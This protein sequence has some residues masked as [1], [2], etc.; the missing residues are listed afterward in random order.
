MGRLKYYNPG[1]DTWEYIMQGPAGVGVPV[2]G[3]TG[4]AL[5]KSSNDDYDTDWTTL[6]QDLIGDGSTYKQY[7]Q[8]EKTKLGY[9]AITQAVNLDTMES[10]L[11]SHIANT[12]NPHSVTKSQVGLG[13]ADNT[14]DVN[15]PI[16]TATQ[17]AL[18]AKV[19]KNANITGAT[20]TKLTYDAKGL[21]TAGADATQDDIGDGTT[22]KQYSA[23]DKT[24]L[25]GIEALADVTDTA[26]VTAAGALMDSEVTNLAAVKAFNPAAYAT[27]AQGTTADSAV[28]PGDDV[29][30]LV[31]DAG[32]ITTHSTA[33]NDGSFRY[34]VKASAGSDSN[35]GLTSGTAFQTL[36]KALSFYNEGTTDLRIY[37]AE[38]GTYTLEGTNFSSGVALH[39]SS[40]VSGVTLNLDVNASSFAFYNNHLNISGV[41]T[42][43]R[44]VITGDTFHLDNADVV[45]QFTNIAQD[46]N[47]YGSTCRMES[48]GFKEIYAVNSS[49]YA[50]ATDVTNT[51]PART[52]VTLINSNYNSIGTW[53]V[54]NLSGAG[55]VPFF[56]ASG[57]RISMESGFL[58]TIANKYTYAWELH[59]TILMITS[60]RYLTG[61]DVAA[62][63]VSNDNS[64]VIS[65][66]LDGTASLSYASGWSGTNAALR[67]GSEVAIL[68]GVFTKTSNIASGDVICTIPAGYRPD[69][70]YYTAAVGSTVD[71][72]A[73]ISINNST[74]DVTA[75][76]PSA[77]T[78][79]LAFSIS[80]FWAS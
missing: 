71:K 79:V 53:T 17:T 24:K 54:S 30:D 55:S 74:G 4:Q 6:T 61:T 69:V 47:L 9:I 8:T 45:F 12:S 50:L 39:L 59:E 66:P 41:D 1:T 22:Y 44:L 27:A 42:S 72:Q 7:S 70:I 11:S 5:T 46:F 37:L 20:K 62:S 65:D 10:D 51:D 73:R 26:N 28:Q 18:D 13:N 19:A 64:K 35:D 34:Y 60:T 40:T 76:N 29:S 38:A 75:L 15:K 16:S 56:I 77:T 43:N 68:S 21:V 67:R 49:I 33:Y 32:Y 36:E 58:N 80:Y 78:T 2:A 25:A 63:R 14:S 52:P 48:C 23:T 3:T 57:S 31:N